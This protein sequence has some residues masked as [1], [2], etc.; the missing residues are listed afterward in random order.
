M[1]VYKRSGAKS[2]SVLVEFGRG[3]GHRRRVYEGGFRTKREAL[4]REVAIK[5]D[6]ANGSWV[7][8][9][10]TTVGDYMKSWLHQH[11]HNL[12]PTTV[13]SYS[14]NLRNHVLPQLG[15][16][17]LQEL[18]AAHLNDFYATLLTQGRVK[19]GSDKGG[20]LSPTTVRYIATIVGKSLQDALE[21]GLVIRNVAVAARKPRT[22]REA[23]QKVK[24][25]SGPEVARFLE[26]TSEDRLHPLWV[27][28]ATTGLRRGEALGLR[29]EDIDLSRG[30]A[31]IRHNLVVV[32][33]GLEFGSPKSGRGRH[34]SLA[35]QTVNALRAWRATQVAEKLAIGAVWA[36]PLGL[37]FTREDGSP[38]HPDRVTDA[39]RR[40][41]KTTE[42]PKITLHQLRHTWAT[43]ALQAGVQPKIVSENLGHSSIRITM[44]IYSHVL[45]TMTSDAVARV[46]DAIYGQDL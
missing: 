7:D 12:K 29:W 27:L 42:L 35:T 34:I 31:S 6:M 38:I 43:L 24:T 18:T 25:W 1:T 37:V 14:A 20:P 3:A 26:S 9:S 13:Q 30:Q 4:A 10:N 15:H 22:S 40:S 16:I 41:Q 23:N 44:D 45:P 36:D 2:W 28:Y 21:S 32:R 39:F 46:A 5:G 33:G 11:G 19:T 8:L 17:Q